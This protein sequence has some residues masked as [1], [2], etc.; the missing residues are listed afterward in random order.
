MHPDLVVGGRFPDL[1]LV[2]HRG[3]PAT[4]SAVARGFPLVVT[5]YR[6]WW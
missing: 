6:G 1:E 3:Q 5:F 4:L 2:D